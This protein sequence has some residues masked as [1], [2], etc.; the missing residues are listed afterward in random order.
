MWK[1]FCIRQPERW[2]RDASCPATTA[3]FRV[4]RASALR[5]LEGAVTLEPRPRALAHEHLAAVPLVERRGP[6]RGGAFE[7][8]PPT[9]DPTPTGARDAVDIGSE[10]P[11]RRDG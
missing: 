5:H 1:S 11:V 2:A 3:R 8:D 6:A 7:D 4:R 9:L 10:R